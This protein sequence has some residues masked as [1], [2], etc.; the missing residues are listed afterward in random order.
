MTTAFATAGT[1]FGRIDIVVNNA[2]FASVGEVEI[3]DEADARHVFETNFWG[4][5]RVT[6]EAVRFLRDVNPAGTGGRLLQISSYL[7][8]VGYPGTAF[9]SASKFGASSQ[10]FHILHVRS[11][12]PS[13]VAVEG[14]TESLAKEL[15]PAWNIKA[16]RLDSRSPASILLISALTQV[17]I[18]EPGWIYSEC[19]PK[20]KWPGPQHIV[21]GNPDT[22]TSRMR[23]EG[24]SVEWKD[25]KRS[26]E[27]FYR[28]ASIPDPPLH[29]IVGRDAIAATRSKVL[30][31]TE[32]ADRFESWSVGLEATA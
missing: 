32:T 15:D 16:C 24:F 14:M 31:L 25:T 1:V 8:F 3:T 23:K 9:Y 4:T 30:E 12:Q 7:G 13:N 2:G 21:Y 28:F 22:P 26:V 19:A 29:F 10:N 6:K 18:I 5:L 20:A 11:S 27:T 17:T